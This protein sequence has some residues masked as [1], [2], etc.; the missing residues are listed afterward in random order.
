MSSYGQMS[1]LIVIRELAIDI[2]NEHPMD[3]AYLLA[4]EEIVDVANKAIRMIN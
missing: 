3:P 1:K 4:V 2:L